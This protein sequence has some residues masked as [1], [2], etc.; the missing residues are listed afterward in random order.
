[1]SNYVSRINR[2]SRINAQVDATC[3]VSL[4]G[5]HMLKAGV[6][7][8]RR[9][10]DV[11]AGQSANQINLFWD[12]AIAGQRGLYG[13][14]RVISNPTDPKRGRITIG[15]VTTPPSASSYRTPGPCPGD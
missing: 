10:N 15:D 1:M 6:Q 5:Q 2:L 8:D 4:A 14:Y 13:Y 7:F 11:D 3:F 12:G 9:A